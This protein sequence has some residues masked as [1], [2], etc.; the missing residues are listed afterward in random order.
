MSALHDAG[1]RCLTLIKQHTDMEDTELA[2]LCV[3]DLKEGFKNT[4]QD[5]T[6]REIAD[7]YVIKRR[8]I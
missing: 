3:A 4:L 5:H 8:T 1:K 2:D 6:I 7:F